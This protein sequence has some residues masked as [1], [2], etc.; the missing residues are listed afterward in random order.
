MNSKI[1]L[2]LQS[3]T[4]TK[5]VRE[6]PKNFEALLALADSQIREEREATNSAGCDTINLLITRC[7]P[8]PKAAATTTSILIILL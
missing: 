4:K 7:A 5:R 1:T 6:L 3:Q 2:K 8:D